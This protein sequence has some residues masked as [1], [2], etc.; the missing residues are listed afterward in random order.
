MSF[1]DEEFVSSGVYEGLTR[2]VFCVAKA[3]DAIDAAKQR[4]S[5]LLEWN[6]HDLQYNYDTSSQE[7]KVKIITEIISIL[8]KE[9]ARLCK[10]QFY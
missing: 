9:A 7:S 3:Q 5:A 2:A 4:L 6:S 8:T 10:E 1:G